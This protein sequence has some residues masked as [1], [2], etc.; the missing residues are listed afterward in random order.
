M[1]NKNLIAAFCVAG[2]VLI[3]AWLWRKHEQPRQTALRRISLFASALTD[4]KGTE[5]LEHAILPAAI[6]ALTPSEQVEFLRKALRDEISLEG[7]QALD[8]HAQFGGL[9]SVFPSE[10]DTWSSLAGVRADDCVAFRMERG[11]VRAEV[12]LLHQGGIYR[13]VRCNNVKQMAIV[14]RPS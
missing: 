3:G 10:A 14:G 13:I 9:K 12:I 8:R 4:P 5:L 7:V 11:G 6:R 1:K 2:L